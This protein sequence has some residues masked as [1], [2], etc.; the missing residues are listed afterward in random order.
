MATN[1]FNRL[2][3]S[4]YLWEGSRGKWIG[5]IKWLES[6]ALELTP[7]TLID[8]CITYR[9]NRQFSTYIG[10]GKDVPRTPGFLLCYTDGSG[11]PEG[12]GS[13]CAAYEGTYEDPVHK[14]SEFTGVATVFQSELY[15][16]EM[17]CEFALQQVPS[18][19]TVLSNSQSAIMAITNPLITSNTVL[20]TVDA[21]NKLVKHGSSVLVRWV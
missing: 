1:T 3:F 12:S 7:G 13:G 16:I 5:H 17:A 6:K 18:P 20:R 2:K 9:W 8:R 14:A 21:L 4:P 15:A 10:D 11:H 19:V